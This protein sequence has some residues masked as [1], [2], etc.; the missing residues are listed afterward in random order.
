MDPSTRADSAGLEQLDRQTCYALLAQ[1][2]IGRLVFTLGALPAVEP[3]HFVL[4][5]HDVLI[6]ADQRLI[7]PAVSRLT[8]VAFEADEYDPLTRTGWCVVL[9]G[10][11]RADGDGLRISPEIVRGRWIRSVPLPA[12]QDTAVG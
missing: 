3:V 11:S 10:R 8:V 12:V 2:S 9:I 5:G 7:L 4:D 1:A 6:G